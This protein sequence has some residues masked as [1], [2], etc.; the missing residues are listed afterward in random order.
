MLDWWVHG[1]RR[2]IGDLAGSIGFQKFEF[3]FFQTLK[4]SGLNAQIFKLEL[5][6]LDFDRKPICGVPINNQ[7]TN[8]SRTVVPS[9][10]EL[11]EPNRIVT[12][13]R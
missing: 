6:K 11:V 5:W 4:R 13:S 8:N 9:S 2:S 3:D 1:S 12:E 7:D 10:F